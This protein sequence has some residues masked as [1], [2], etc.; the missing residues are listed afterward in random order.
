MIKFLDLHH[1][2][3]SIK[4]EIDNAIRSNIESSSF[5]GG[6]SLRN[7]ETEFAQYLQA[8]YCIGVGNGTDALEI[9]IEALNLPPQSEILVPANSFIASAEA[10]TRTGNNVVFIDVDQNTRNLNLESAKNKLTKYTRA[11][12]AVHLYGNPCDMKEIMLFAKNNNLKIIE[13][14]AQAHGGK[15]E[16]KSLGSFGDIAAFS[17]YPGKNL[18]AYG[19]GGAIVTNDKELA[20]KARMISNHGRIEKYNHLMEGRNSRLD[21]IQAKILSVKLKYLDSWIKRRN[22]IASYYNSRFIEFTKSIKLPIT[23]SG[24]YHAYHL[25]VIQTNERDSLREYL[26]KSNIQTGIHYP[27]SLPKLDAYKYLKQED[28]A[29]IS[30]NMSNKLISLPIGEH[31]TNKEIEEVADKV[32]EFF[33]N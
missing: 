33:K 10:I 21:S 14:C 16:N 20:K 17:F 31:L 28:N 1:Q 7:F 8:N 6:D 2:Y 25:Y 23:I 11:L 13:D 19:D 29:P 30:I 27:I 24:N 4:D 3:L 12:I 5:I 22:E 18:G 26:T 15:I 9:S 32:I